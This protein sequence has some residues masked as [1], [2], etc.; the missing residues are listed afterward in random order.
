L[1]AGLLL[2]PSDESRVFGT[3]DSLLQHLEDASQIETQQRVRIEPQA[4]ELLASQQSVGS[5]L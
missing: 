5:A 3:G 1:S 4:G 2:E